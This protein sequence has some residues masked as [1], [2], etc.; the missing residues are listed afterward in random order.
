MAESSARC[1]ST[2]TGEGVPA[3]LDEVLTG[4]SQSGTRI[5]DIDYERYARAEARLAWLNCKV[6]VCLQAP[7]S[8]STLIGPLLE[9]LDAALTSEG[10]QIAH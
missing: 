2:L 7:L 6:E 5:L 10:F 3:W 9:E 4:K 1:L 8:P